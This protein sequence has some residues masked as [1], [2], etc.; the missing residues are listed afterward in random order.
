MMLRLRARLMHMSEVKG[1][2]TNICFRE[3]LLLQRHGRTL[4]LVT[5]RVAAAI[6]RIREQR[7]L[8]GGYQDEPP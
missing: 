1:R 7:P 4:D 3:L 2:D 5:R 6:L 8:S